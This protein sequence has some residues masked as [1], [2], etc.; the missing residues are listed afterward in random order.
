MKK[1][2]TLLALALVLMLG[3]VSQATFGLRQWNLS[4]VDEDLGDIIASGN[5]T[6]TI[7]NAGVATAGSIYS[8]EA[9]TVKTNPVTPGSDAVS[10]VGKLKF[11]C[12]YTSID[13]KIESSVYTRTL[14]YSSVGITTKRLVYRRA[15][16]L[17]MT[18]VV[19]DGGSGLFVRA[20]S[21]TAT[22]TSALAGKFWGVVDGTPNGITGATTSELYL[23]SDVTGG[24]YHY[25][26]FKAKIYEA[27]ATMA[28]SAVYPLYL[29]TQ[30]DSTSAPANH[31]MIRFNTATS[32][33]TPDTLFWA[34]NQQAI[35]W[36]TN[37]AH[38]ASATDKT[39]AIKILII[40]TAGDG[41]GYHYIY[42]YSNPGQ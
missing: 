38:G 11:Y 28:N 14:K 24:T 30:M 1:K 7:Y 27:G 2:I 20:T 17:Q 26:G 32:G 42:T 23:L 37:S 35:A 34:S 21:T 40:G 10:A 15:Q 18:M 6:I 8:D 25:Y 36:A 13:V 22:S 16:L 31:T 9:M 29:E 3:S 4:I 12:A 39:G 19:P 41:S 33:D 5:F